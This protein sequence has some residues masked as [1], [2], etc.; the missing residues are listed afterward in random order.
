MHSKDITSLYLIQRFFN[1]GNVTLHGDSAMYQVIR[2]SDLACVIKHFNDYPLK[3]QKH[4][5]FLLFKKAFDIINNKQ[6]LTESGLRNLI[7]IR[8]SMN[9]GLPERLEAAFPKIIPV[10][11]PTV[12]KANFESNTSDIK[13]WVS[14][15]MSGEA[16]F[17]IKVSKSKTHKLGSSTALYFLVNQ[18]IRDAYLLENFTQF[19]DCGSF[20]IKE[21]SDIATFTVTNFNNILE[22]VIPFFVE[23]PILGIKSKDF[24]DFKQASLLIKSKTH[25]T[26]QGFDEILLIKSRM[27]FKRE[28]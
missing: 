2:L 3:T 23:Y 19:F 28:L 5:D 9:K 16:C 22:K 13:Y 4:A 15:F 8:A 20:S 10:E 14:G 24:E 26:R 11:R 6:H 17:M 18:H 21:K 25:L 7:S 1:V 27:N 12:A